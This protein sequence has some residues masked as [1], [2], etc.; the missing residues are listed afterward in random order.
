MSG[1]FSVGMGCLIL[2]FV[3][4]C[5][6]GF[7]CLFCFCFVVFACGAC[8]HSSGEMLSSMQIVEDEKM[9]FFDVSY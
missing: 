7:L 5:F 4:V 2:Y 9:L 8:V 1:P 6:V 3:L